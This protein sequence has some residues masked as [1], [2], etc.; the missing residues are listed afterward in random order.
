LRPALAN[1]EE[2]HDLERSARLAALKALGPLR[3]AHLDALRS[4]D[5]LSQ[6][7]PEL[8]E[9]YD[10]EGSARFDVLRSHSA[11]AQIKKPPI[12][13]LDP[14]LGWGARRRRRSDEGGRGMLPWA[15]RGQGRPNKGILDFGEKAQSPLLKWLNFFIFWFRIRRGVGG[16]AAWAP[17]GQGRPKR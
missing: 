15:F 16:G 11:Y 8:E 9:P 10:L 13:K 5:S 17:R 3:L 12:K 6:V 1:P 14:T 4:L 2:S 7:P